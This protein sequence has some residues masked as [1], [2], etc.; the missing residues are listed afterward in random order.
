M[1][2]E[3]KAKLRLEQEFYTKCAEL[4][5]CDHAYH[6]P[7]EYKTRWNVRT[8]GNGRYEGH[9]VIRM[10]SQT[11]IRVMLSN[12]KLIRTYDNVQDVYAA[13]EELV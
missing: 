2:E 9:G 12:P 3:R 13:L 6:E 8:L 11:C 7:Y 10:Y 1:K 5:S 4:L